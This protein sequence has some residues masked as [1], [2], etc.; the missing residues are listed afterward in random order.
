MKMRSTIPLLLMAALAFASCSK[1]KDNVDPDKETPSEGAYFTKMT[2]G[3]VPGDD[4]VYLV[5]YDANHRIT[6][7]INSSWEDTLVGTYNNAGY[8]SSI[9]ETEGGLGERV[10]FTYNANNQVTEV[11]T[12]GGNYKTKYA[13]EYT[14]GIVSKKSYYNNDPVDGGPLA[15]WRYYTYEVTNGNITSMKEYDSQGAAVSE[16]KYTYNADPNVFQAMAVFNNFNLLGADDIAN[17]ETAF[18]KNL[19]TSLSYKDNYYEYTA[20][21]TYTYNDHKQLAKV[22]VSY[23]DQVFT[24]QFAY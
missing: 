11:N 18:N 15:L 23:P 6:K 7:I 5:S 13:F 3:L 1:D 8:V 21:Y 22:V 16:T 24:R 20:T 14:N 10:N 9:T 2:Q 17:L 12:Q 4:T 19:I